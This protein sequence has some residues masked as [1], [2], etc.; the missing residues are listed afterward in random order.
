MAAIRDIL[1]TFQR[2]AGRVPRIWYSLVAIAAAAMLPVLNLMGI[3]ETSWLRVG[4]VSLIF[5]MLSLG[6]N[7]IMGETGLLNLGYIAFFAFGSYTTALLSSSKFELRWPFWA[8]LVL[9]ALI[10]MLAGFVIGLPTLRL[11]GDYLAIVTLAF[12]EIVRLT[13]TNLRPYTNGPSGITGI[14]PPRLLSEG[15]IARIETAMGSNVA[16]WLT[17]DRPYEY[18][19][20]VLVLVV[21]AAWLL[22]NLKNSRIGRAWNA[23]REDELAAVSAG[24]TA[25]R[26]KLVSLI[27]SAGIA[28]LAGS[29]FAYYSQVISPVS[30][31]FMQSVIVVCMVVLGGMGSI[32]G[33]IMGA[34]VLTALPQVIRESAGA[35][36]SDFEVYRMLVFGIIIVVMVMFRPEGLLPDVL[37]RR[38]AHEDDPRELEK[39]RQS[40]FDLEEGE[41]ELEA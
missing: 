22:G 35:M 41:R 12:G 25:S 3:V 4:I 28:G 14:Y 27:L 15:L 24:I 26:A 10:S 13:I 7:I 16:D 19:Y 31:L 20:L 34:V 40:L 39:T 11:R 18:Y 17:V 2:T 9:S 23:L 8:V 36:R 37:W 6:L 38:Q 32:P 1:H 29:I 21:I 30:F 33:V 5:V